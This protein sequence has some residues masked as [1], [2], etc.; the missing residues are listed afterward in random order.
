[1]R[2]MSDAAK[3]LKRTPFFQRHEELGAKLVDFHGWEL[4]IQYTSIMAEH[5]AVR[6]A[7]GLFD[8]SHMGQVEVRGKDS[9]AFLQEIQSNDAGKVQIGRAMYAH[10]LNERGGV[11]DD[12][13]FSRLG[14]E[15]WFIV[16]NAATREKDVAWLKAHAGGREVEIEDRSCE[17]AML[18]LQGPRA[19]ELIGMVCPEAA[20]LKR[21]GV[22]EAEIY[23]RIMIFS[24]TGYTGEDGFEI[25][26]PADIA[27]RIWRTLNVN[28]SSYGL[29][30][31]GL[32]ARDTLR[33]EAGYL[34]YGSDIDE[35]RTP[36][37]AGYDWVVKFSKPGFIGKAALEAQKREGL[38]RRLLG[39]RLTD[40]GV[41]R[42]GAEVVSGGRVLGV[43]ASATFSPTLE[44]GIGVGYLDRPELKS[45]DKVFVRMR[46][47]DLAA[48]IASVPFY[49]PERS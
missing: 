35:E 42:A 7:C 17:Y 16:V 28:G 29:V 13:I 18:A 20:Q 4:P 1:M 41:P 8:V 26:A 30:P 37:E 27:V 48:E 45:G 46:G 21:F 24:R 10:M 25:I 12:I 5:R 43:L 15:R 2:G 44:A 32:G 38:K 31:C 33:L 47:R 40:R 6:A 22:L 11:V 3:T 19:V 9:A 36:L 14:E 49:K 23:G 39:V 34:L